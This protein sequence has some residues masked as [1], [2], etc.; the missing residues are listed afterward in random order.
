M[1]ASQPRQVF[2]DR[3]RGFALLGIVLVNV[4]FLGISSVGFTADSIAGSLDQAAAFFVLA[5]AQGKFYLLFAFLFG[6][7]AAFILRDSGATDRRRYRRRLL[8][9]G[10]LGLLHAIFFFIGDILLIYAVLGVGLLLLSG[11]SD[12]VL[13][14]FAIGA[15]ATGVMLLLLVVVPAVIVDP[16]SAS[17]SDPSLD[18]LN[19]ALID[20]SFLQVAQARLEALPT[21]VILLLLLQGSMVFGG[22]CL[23]LLAARSQLLADPATRVQLWRR[24]ALIGLA[25]GL[26]L[27]LVAAAMQLRVLTDPADATISAVGTAIGLAT[28]PL[29]SAGYLGLAGWAISRYPG[30]LRFAQ[31]PG[32]AS[33][34]VYIGE[35]VV[36]SLIFCGYGLGYFGR[37][38]AFAVVMTGVAAWL[39]LDLAAHLWLK[40]FRQGPLEA[41][42][43]RWTGKRGAPAG[44][45]GTGPMVQPH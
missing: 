41:V 44:P 29:L 2:P 36:L 7:S 14:R 40:R 31:T 42:L 32:R 1:A 12:R 19:A 3:L 38:G 30:A 22:F 18:A 43:A 27:Q 10:V 4:P 6:Y 5:L 20:G 37:W 25:V 34:S 23:G 45:A 13:R 15:A 26:P 8:G 21:V 28:A 24:L 9:L 11:R 16:A 17:R 33:L 39:T 35:S